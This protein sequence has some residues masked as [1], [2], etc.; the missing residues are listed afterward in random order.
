MF[1][2][3]TLAVLESDTALARGLQSSGKALVNVK[4]KPRLKFVTDIRLTT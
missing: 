4:L 1:I 3:I 2:F